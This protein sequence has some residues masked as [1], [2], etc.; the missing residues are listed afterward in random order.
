MPISITNHSKK[1]NQ[2]Y[3]YLQK[4]QDTGLKIATKNESFLQYQNQSLI[5]ME[6]YDN[7]KLESCEYILPKYIKII[8]QKKIFN[9]I[10]TTDLSRCIATSQVYEKLHYI[11]NE[12]HPLLFNKNK[13]ISILILAI[14]QTS[15]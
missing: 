9:E 10:L 13:A 6:Q 11:Q 7:Y 14:Y 3:T 8:L 5:P 15:A 12:I 1:I 2:I 4:Y